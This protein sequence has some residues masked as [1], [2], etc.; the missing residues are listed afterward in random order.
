MY[1]PFNSFQLR[2]MKHDCGEG[3]DDA[4]NDATCEA[5]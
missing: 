1:Q 3:L 4:S 5:V 2:Y